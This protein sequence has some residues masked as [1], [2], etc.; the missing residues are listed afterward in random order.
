MSLAVAVLLPFALVAFNVNATDCLV[1][2]AS[3][4]SAA[5]GSLIASTIALPAGTLLRT[6]ASE[7]V[8]RR[9]PERSVSFPP[10][11]AVAVWSHLIVSASVPTLGFGLPLYLRAESSTFALFGFSVQDATGGLVRTPAVLLVTCDVVDV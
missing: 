1:C 11:V 7:M 10:T 2:R 3:A 4:T 8:L 5:R 6:D 9:L